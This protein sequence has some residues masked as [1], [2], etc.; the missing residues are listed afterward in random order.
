[1]INYSSNVIIHLDILISQMALRHFSL[2]TPSNKK[3]RNDF[4]SG[5]FYGY[6]LALKLHVKLNSATTSPFE[7][8]PTDLQITVFPSPVAIV[9]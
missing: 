3:L 4:V 9:S 6:F 8:V 2:K 1:M 7:F 5:V